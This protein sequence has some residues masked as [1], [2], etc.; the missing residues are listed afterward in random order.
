MASPVMTKHKGLENKAGENNCFLNAAIQTL[1]HLDSFRLLL[2]MSEE[3]NFPST[4]LFVQLKALF[5][6]YEYGDASSL[7]PGAVREALM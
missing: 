7:P 1:W 4:S 3:S 2:Q 6:H 5:A